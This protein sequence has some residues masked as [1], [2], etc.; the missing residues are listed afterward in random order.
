MQTYVPKG[1]HEWFEKIMSSLSFEDCIRPYLKAL[2]SY[3]LS[4][5]CDP[6]QAEELAQETLVRAYEA[7]P[8]LK[9][10][11]AVWAWLIGIARRCSWTWWW[12]A[13]RD[14]LRLADTPLDSDAVDSLPL[15]DGDETVVDQLMREEMDTVILNLIQKLPQ[16]DR[17]VL[18]Y[19]YYEDLSYAAIAERLGLGLE[20]VDQR[21]T[22]AK[23]RLRKYLVR[24]EVIL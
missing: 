14:P 9:N 13:K 11:D 19:R 15:P 6:H 8:R 20:A 4:R 12:K 16:R 22:R 10:R 7:Y 1:I 3:C 23:Q 21:L 5:T 18:I 2:Y 17:E 24:A